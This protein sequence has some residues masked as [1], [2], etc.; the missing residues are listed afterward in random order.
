MWYLKDDFKGCMELLRTVP[1]REDA[2]DSRK[3]YLYSLRLR[4]FCNYRLGRYERALHTLQVLYNLRRGAG[5][6]LANLYDRRDAGI[7]RGRPED[8]H[9]EAKV[10]SALSGYYRLREVAAEEGRVQT[11]SGGSRRFLDLD[12]LSPVTESALD[13]GFTMLRSG[14]I[15]AAI[16]FFTKLRE[17][18]PELLG[19]GR[20][21]Q[22]IGTEQERVRSSREDGP[23]SLSKKSTER[24]VRGGGRGYRLWEYIESWEKNAIRPFHLLIMAGLTSGKMLSP[25]VL[26]SKKK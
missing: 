8:T 4:A 11:S 18:H 16:D 12:G 22:L 3:Q 6:R 2:F 20:I 10:E 24:V 1:Q 23:R 25:G 13:L 19:L 21:I 9:T 14:N 26:L 17:E 5:K 7:A 15:E